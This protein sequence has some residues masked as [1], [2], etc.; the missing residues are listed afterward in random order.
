MIAKPIFI[1]YMG[2]KSG[3]FAPKAVKLTSGDLPLIRNT[4]LRVERSIRLC[5]RSQQ[6]AY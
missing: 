1:K 4:G 6:R 3:G 2:C 5:G